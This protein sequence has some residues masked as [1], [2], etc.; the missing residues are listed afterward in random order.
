MKKLLFI[1]LL[2]FAFNAYAVELQPV[3]KIVQQGFFSKV[4]SKIAEC[5][6]HISCYQPKLGV[7]LTTIT[8]TTLI[9]DLDDVLTTNFTN[10]NNGKI[11]VSTTTLP[12][13]TTLV[14]VTELGVIASS[15]WRGSLI[16]V[17]YGGL[18]TSTISQYRLLL[19]NAG[20]PIT[21]ATSTGTAGQFLVSNGEGANPSWQTK[22]TDTAS[23]YTWTGTHIFNS[24]NVGIATTT[25]A[26]TLSVQGDALISGTTTAGNLIAT[27]TIKSQG[28]IWS[29]GG[30]SIGGTGTTTTA[31]NLRIANNL[32]VD[33]S[34]T[35][36]RLI[37]SN[38][39]ILPIYATTSRSITTSATGNEKVDLI[40][41]CFSGDAV[42]SG[43]FT[44]SDVATAVNVM[45]NNRNDSES[46]RVQTD[47]ISA[48]AVTVTAYAICLDQ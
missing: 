18:G 27:S 28:N 9:S 42:I 34:A 35:T 24:Q 11:E 26:T 12:F 4:F 21:T 48:N 13:L 3:G 23:N 31:A 41:Y 39:A 1:L 7:T 32:I 16:G 19:G 47:N 40:V 6:L 43:G 15:T 25:P 5:T 45:N 10:L 8:G 30:V 14:N 44:M 29:T 20:S 36:S 38:A 37:V 33:G 46:W 22:T 2:V 17:P